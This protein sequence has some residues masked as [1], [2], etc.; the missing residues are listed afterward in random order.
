MIGNNNKKK[1]MDV[2]M[3]TAEVELDAQDP[4]E[5]PQSGP[6]TAKLKEQSEHDPWR[7]LQRTYD[8]DQQDWQHFTSAGLQPGHHTWIHRMMR[9]T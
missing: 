2:E 7:Y 5:E 4:L 9:G 8:A 1:A 6:S 3:S